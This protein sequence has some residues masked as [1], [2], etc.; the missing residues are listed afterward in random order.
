MTSVLNVDTIADKAGTGPVGLTKQEAVKSLHTYDQPAATS[1]D[2][3]NISSAT[4]N[5]D[6]E[7][8]HTFSSA[9]SS[10][11]ARQVMV[12]A[13]NTADG[14]SNAIAA[15]SRGFNAYQ[16]HSNNAT[17]TVRTFTG[18]GSTGSADGYGDDCDATY[19]AVLGDLA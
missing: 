11:T 6:G 17:T 14:G 10:A 16:Y 9:F 13:W 15:N 19:L 8:T 4:D 18:R 7:V 2:S 3:L 1:V 5:T 12:S